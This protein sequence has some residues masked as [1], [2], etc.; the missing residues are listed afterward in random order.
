MKGSKFLFMST[1]KD[2]E[3]IC[4]YKC[5][6][7]SVKR[8]N[9]ISRLHRKNCDKCAAESYDAKEFVDNLNEEH[10]KIFQSVRQYHKLEALFS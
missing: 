7:T 5:Q 2:C 6:A 4:G 9:L 8:L 3:F 1:Q 10:R